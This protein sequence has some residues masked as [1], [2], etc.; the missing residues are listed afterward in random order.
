MDSVKIKAD[1]E[2]TATNAAMYKKPKSQKQVVKVYM[3]NGN[4][5]KKVIIKSVYEN[6]VVK[7][8][9]VGLIK[10]GTVIFNSGILD[11]KAAMEA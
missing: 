6:G 10:N 3:D 9:N 7:E 4:I 2:L 1:Q 8:T 11:I 5:K